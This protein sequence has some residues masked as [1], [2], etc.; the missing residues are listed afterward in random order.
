MVWLESAV[1]LV[2]MVSYGWEFARQEIMR[3]ENGTESGLH[4]EVRKDALLQQMSDALDGEL[5]V[6][7]RLRA[8]V[9][10][11]VEVH[12]DGVGLSSR[13][14]CPGPACAPLHTYTSTHCGC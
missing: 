9:L 5:R 3:E 1:P 14:G 11:R 2:G 8:E 6:L 13:T 7:L 4:P 10:V 12:G